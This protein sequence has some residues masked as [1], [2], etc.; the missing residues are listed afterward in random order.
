MDNGGFERRGSQNRALGCRLSEQ[1]AQLR[2][3]G[4][5]LRA[6]ENPGSLLAVEFKKITGL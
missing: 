4:S 3:P 1:A 2:E 6:Q 5:D